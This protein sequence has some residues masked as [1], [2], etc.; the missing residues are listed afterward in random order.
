M[1]QRVDDKCSHDERVCVY[2]IVI[3]VRA[4]V[5]NE[6]MCSCSS[7]NE[8]AASE[9]AFFE[10]HE[11]IISYAQLI[12]TSARGEITSIP[13]IAPRC[14]FQPTFPIWWGLFAL[15]PSLPVHTIKRSINF[16]LFA[17]V[18]ID[19]FMFFPFFQLFF[20]ACAWQCMYISH[21]SIEISFFQRWPRPSTC[22]MRTERAEAPDT[23]PKFRWMHAMRL[24]I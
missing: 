5:V 24:K 22:R 1:V 17:A 14:A 18:Q 12:I 2:C 7:P 10:W 21:F 6:C 9:N 3:C 11:R 15:P 16:V 20:I 8:L 4:R 23:W 13:P 19:A